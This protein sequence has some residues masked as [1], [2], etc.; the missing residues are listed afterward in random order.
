MWKRWSKVKITSHK[1]HAFTDE[2]GK[3]REGKG[4]SGERHFSQTQVLSFC[5]CSWA[6][7]ILIAGKDHR[8]IIFYDKILLFIKTDQKLC[9]KNALLHGIHGYYF[10]KHFSLLWHNLNPIWV[11][12]A[13]GPIS[14]QSWNMRAPFQRYYG[15][16]SKPPS[17]SSPPVGNS[18]QNSEAMA[19]LCM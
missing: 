10:K 12:K 15:S 5:P 3:G 13:T 14:D 17:N 11:W 16:K 19:V 18:R 6:N 2:E 1:W 8:N 9:S 4:E 7:L